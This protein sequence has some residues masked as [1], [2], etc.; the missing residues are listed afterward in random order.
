MEKKCYIV[1][2]NQQSYDGNIITKL[3]CIPHKLS[4]SKSN[5]KQRQANKLRRK[6]W[7]SNLGCQATVSSETYV[8]QRHF[9][10]GK[11]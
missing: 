10:S 4:A 3:Y 7:L 8:C 6:T 9:V 2:C 11:I 5:L 1:A